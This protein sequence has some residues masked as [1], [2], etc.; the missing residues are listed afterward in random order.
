MTPAGQH[1]QIGKVVKSAALGC[2]LHCVSQREVIRFQHEN[3]AISRAT[4]DFPLPAWGQD[5]SGHERASKCTGVVSQAGC[6]FPTQQNWS[7]TSEFDFSLPPSEG[8][9]MHED[10]RACEPTSWDGQAYKMPFDGLKFLA[11]SG[12]TL[13][14]LGMW[15]G[16]IQAVRVIFR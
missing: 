12:W 5:Q 9:G 4:S 10:W 15:A 16:I 6:I 1:F 3:H 2:V 11:F 7:R 14:S 13:V 8:G